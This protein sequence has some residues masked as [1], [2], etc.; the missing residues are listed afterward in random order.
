MRRSASGESPISRE[1]FSKTI[2]DQNAS[3]G[4]ESFSVAVATSSMTGHR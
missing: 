4:G 2:A 3:P 1:L